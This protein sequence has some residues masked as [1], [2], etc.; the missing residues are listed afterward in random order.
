MNSSHIDLLP[1]PCGLADLTSTE[2]LNERELV[3][4]AGTEATTLAS[5]QVIEPFFSRVHLP[6]LE[7]PLLL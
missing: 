3:S 5:Q 7:P 6:I 4:R 2:V 1:V